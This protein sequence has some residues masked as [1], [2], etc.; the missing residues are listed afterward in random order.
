MRA[1]V[2]SAWSR[3]VCNLHWLMQAAAIQ[4][5]VLQRL[6]VVTLR[7]SHCLTLERKGL[8][9]F[10]RVRHPKVCREGWWAM[11]QKRFEYTDFQGPEL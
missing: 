3:C 10:I 11:Q 6:T 4:G 7:V 1:V 5:A 8:L 9:G 2:R